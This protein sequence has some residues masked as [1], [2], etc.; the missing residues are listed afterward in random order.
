MSPE[1]EE[2]VVTEQVCNEKFEVV[3]ERPV[4]AYKRGTHIVVLKSSLAPPPEWMRH[5]P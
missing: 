2:I 1:L 4:K 3:I 5:S